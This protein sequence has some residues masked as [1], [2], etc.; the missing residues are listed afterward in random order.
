MVAEIITKQSHT[1]HTYG[2]AASA[3]RPCTSQ[4][5]SWQ[6]WSDT[7]DS[8]HSTSAAATN[9]KRL[10]SRVFKMP[11]ASSRVRDTGPQIGSSTRATP[12]RRR[13]QLVEEGRSEQ[14]EQR[15][16]KQLSG[17]S[18]STRPSNT[19][20]H[21]KHVNGNG[22]HAHSVD[23]DSDDEDEYAEED[24][25]DVDLLV[26]QAYRSMT[27]AMSSSTSLDTQSTPLTNTD[28]ITSA[29][30]SRHA[31]SAMPSAVWP[32][33][34]LSSGAAVVRL[35]APTPQ[36]LFTR[37]SHLFQ[38]TQPPTPQPQPTAAPTRSP[39]ASSHYALPTPQLTAELKRD[40]RLLALRPYLDPKRF[41][42]RS[43]R[44]PSHFPSQF[45]VGTVVEAGEGWYGR[46]VA[47][48]RREWWVEGVREEGG[49]WLKRKFEEVQEK[50]K[51]RERG[52]DQGRKKR[53][54]RR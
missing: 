4:P 25:A 43:D 50:N 41:Y 49:Q 20:G 19:N 48:E 14:H 10:I 9:T 5:L 13:N 35:T 6:A 24:E 16:E 3:S 11:R 42:K 23:E 29:S 40:L 21:H 1:R 37:H 28:D 32:G 38:L 33:L 22:Q 44:R 27:A 2:P 45:A 34:G 26:Q 39:A 8:C 53:K 52:R 54:G 17:S 12:R 15:E 51:G 46:E 30:T 36:P 18:H 7:F 47:S 31:T